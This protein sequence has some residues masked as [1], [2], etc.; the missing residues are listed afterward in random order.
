MSTQVEHISC[1]RP[2]IEFAPKQKEVFIINA[3]AATKTGCRVAISYI[4]VHF[5]Q[6][7]FFVKINLKAASVQTTNSVIEK[8]MSFVDPFCLGKLRSVCAAE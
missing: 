3:H 4:T 5:L 7:L 6:V 1:H 8:F 2:L